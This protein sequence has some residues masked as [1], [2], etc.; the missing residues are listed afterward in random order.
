MY[1]R[2]GALGVVVLLAGACSAA[3]VAPP[4]STPETLRALDAETIRNGRR[5]YVTNC[6]GCHGLNAQGAQ[7]WQRP[8]DNG[9]MPPPPQDDSGHTWRHSDRQLAEIILDGWRDPFN[10]TPDLT[11]PPFRGKLS[12]TDVEAVITYFKSLWSDEHRRYQLEETQKGTAASQTP[13]PL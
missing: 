9:N 4:V 6:A 12:D 2:L 7:N 1:L 10:K 3:L 13:K 8:D 5:V 11:M